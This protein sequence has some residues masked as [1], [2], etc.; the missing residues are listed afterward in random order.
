MSGDRKTMRLMFRNLILPGLT[1]TAK[2]MALAI[3]VAWKLAH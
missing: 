1:G 2:A 3:F